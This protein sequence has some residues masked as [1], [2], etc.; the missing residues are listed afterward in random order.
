MLNQDSNPRRS[1]PPLLR[2]VWV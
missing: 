1:P 2:K